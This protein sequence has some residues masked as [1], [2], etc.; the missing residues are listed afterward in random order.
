MTFDSL[1]ERVAEEFRSQMEDE[2]FE[3]FSEAVIL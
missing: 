2:G 3:T 1:A